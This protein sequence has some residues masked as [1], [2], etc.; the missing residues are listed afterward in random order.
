MMMAN[1]AAAAIQAEFQEKE[2]VKAALQ[3]AI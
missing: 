3:N 1:Q 2:Q